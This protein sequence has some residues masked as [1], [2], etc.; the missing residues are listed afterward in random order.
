MYVSTVRSVVRVSCV[1]WKYHARNSDHYIIDYWLVEHSVGHSI[2]ST[3]LVQLGFGED[4]LEA[5]SAWVSAPKSGSS[6]S[7]SSESDPSSSSE[8]DQEQDS[9]EMDIDSDAGAE[10]TQEMCQPPSDPEE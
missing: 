8:S 9:E 2:R 7:S 6:L 3:N 5:V 4:E 1:P 10:A